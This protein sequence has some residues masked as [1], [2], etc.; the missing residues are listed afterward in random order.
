VVASFV[1]EL[2]RA[3]SAPRHDEYRPLGGSDL[4]MAVNYF[5]NVALSEALYPEL[6]AL[7]VC[8]RNGIHNALA[9]AYASDLWFY[10]PGLLEPRQ[11][12][13]FANARL[14]LFRAH[15][16]Q[17][18]ADR[19]VAEL[20]FG[21]WITL[22][23][24]N[25]HRTVWNPN[26]AAL[27]RSVFPHLSGPRFQRQHIHERFNKLRLLRN[28][29]FHHEP[30]WD[31]ATLRQNHADIHTAIGWISPSVLETVQ[32]HDRFAD[33]YANERARIETKLKSHLGAP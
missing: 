16:N 12:R 28:R 26:H 15:G 11:L 31:R 1:A 5:W 29:V 6:A 7:E 30:I 13:E 25:Y 3:V 19:L 32:L 27:L 10:E 8:L 14:N 9:T 33:V 22:L 20:T 4:D 2:R 23:S 17:P 21:F 18:S 24:R